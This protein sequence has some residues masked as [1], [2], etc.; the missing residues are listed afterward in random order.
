VKSI[1]ARISGSTN[2]RATL[3]CA[4]FLGASSEIGK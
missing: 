1:W 3:L 4:S 2:Q